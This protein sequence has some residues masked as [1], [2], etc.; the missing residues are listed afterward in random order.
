M[1]LAKHA[2][3]H[4]LVAQAK[5]ELK[6]QAEVQ[7]AAWMKFVKTGNQKIRPPEQDD[8]WYT[9]AASVLRQIQQTGNVGV[10]RLR[11]YYGGR[12][13]LGHAPPH[14]RKTG[15]NHLRKILQQLEKAGLV[16]KGK[17]GRKLTAKGQ[18]FL[19]RVAKNV[20]E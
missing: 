13:Q 17:K 2:N 18:S 15:G 11:T 14:F 5:E 7:P 16:E 8:F 1:V 4:K 3:P 19:D 20:K 6:K 12:K 10:E 9:R